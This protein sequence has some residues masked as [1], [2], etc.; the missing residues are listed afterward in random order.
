MTRFISIIALTAA[1]LSGTAVKAQTT[2]RLSASKANDY[3]VVYTLPTTA[4]Q[5]TVGAEKTVSKPG[6]FSVLGWKYLKATPILE[7]TTRWRLSEAY[8]TPVAVADESERYLVTLK[9]GTGTFI[10]VNG[11][12]APLAI[13]DEK[14][15]PATESEPPLRPV[16]AK[17]TVLEKPV[18]LQ[19][20][21]EEMLQ[22]H[23]TVHR[24]K[25]AAAKIYEL[26]TNRNE[27]VAGQ[28][29]AM[30]T[31]G[32]AM[33]LALETIDN[34]EEALTAMFLGT[35]SK[36]L[37]VATYDVE[38]PAMD[39][40][41]KR[42]IIGR[43]SATEGFVN[44]EN[45]SGAPIYLTV[46]PLTEGKLPLDEKGQERTMPKGGVAYRIPGTAKVTLE[47]D[48]RIVAE[49]VISVAQY[50][51]TYGIDPSLFTNKKSPSYAHFDPLTGAL[52][53]IGEIR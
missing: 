52:L 5:I 16:S 37:E 49:K 12:N 15:T 6:E 35:T 14:Y 1:L 27:L 7:E 9:G 41:G 20:Q 29:D 43:L 28:A 42:M 23:S 22:S 53:E 19:A 44:A 18:A 39:D 36:S 2:Q 26:R 33:K 30:P 34:Q 17:P 45:L 32:N 38:I 50:G 25:M 4:I 10:T 11:S 24:A 46:T 13:N 47:F 8:I 31:D 21:T 48:G 3:G 40:A 51:V